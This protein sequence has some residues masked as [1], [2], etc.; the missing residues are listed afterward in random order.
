MDKP[1]RL[2]ARVRSF[3]YAFAGL[4]TVLATQHNAWIHSA[5]TAAVLA[6][7]VAVGLSP[8]EWCW[9]VVAVLAVWATEALNTAIEFLADTVST[10]PHPL[11]GQA[12][13]CAAGAVLLAAVGAVAIGLLVFYPHA[14]ALW[15][16]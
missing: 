13:D 11:V 4:R 7:G 9:I 12:K 8:P 15:H 3:R 14:L 16:K 5:V 1:F 2:D 10:A 6:A